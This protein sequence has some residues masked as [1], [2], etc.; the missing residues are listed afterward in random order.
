MTFAHEIQALSKDLWRTGF[1]ECPETCD[2]ASTP[3]KHCK[4]ECRADVWSIGSREVLYQAGTLSSI[5]YFDSTG[6]LINTFL[7]ENGKV[8]HVTS[9]T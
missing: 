1:L 5:T 3:S 4:C 6:H 7:D 8:F 2:L 9:P